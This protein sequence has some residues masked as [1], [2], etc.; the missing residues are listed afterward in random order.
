MEQRTRF[1]SKLSAST[2]QL[3]KN[4]RI[5]TNIFLYLW[6]KLLILLKMKQRTYDS[7]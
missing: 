3:K 5:F 7:I 1:L 6:K 4:I 2:K